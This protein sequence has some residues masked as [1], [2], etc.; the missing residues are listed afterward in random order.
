MRTR[1]Q[2]CTAC[3]RTQRLTAYQTWSGSL[4]GEALHDYVI[5]IVIII[6]YYYCYYFIVLTE[7][8][9]VLMQDE[10]LRMQL[11]CRTKPRAKTVAL[12]DES[13]HDGAG[14]A[15]DCSFTLESTH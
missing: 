9:L 3:S 7:I 10:A 11:R 8:L 15:V 14:T 2:T 4:Q 5:R 1:S 6:H 13:L 12:Q